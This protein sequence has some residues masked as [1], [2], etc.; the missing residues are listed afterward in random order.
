MTET[1]PR[2][3]ALETVLAYHQAWTSGDIDGAMADVADDIVCRAPG[4][5]ITGKDAYGGFLAG[6]A[7]NLTG[8]SDVATF[9][10]GDHVALFYYPQTAVTST[11][12]AAE[13]FTV[14]GGRIVEN[15]LVFDRL[16]FVPPDEQ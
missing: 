7:P 14:R 2:S 9:V 12:P 8:L 5:D 15:L 1:E 13:Y 4:G 3:T 10:D 6:F 16:S 11:A